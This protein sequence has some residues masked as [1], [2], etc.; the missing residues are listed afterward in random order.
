[1]REPDSFHGWVWTLS[2]AASRQ[3]RAA[4][5]PVTIWLVGTILV[6][7]GAQVATSVTTGVPVGVATTHLFYVRPGLA[8]VLSPLL[9]RGPMHAATNALLIGYLGRLVEGHFGTRAYAA[10]LVAATVGSVTGG[11]LAIV[12]FRSG[13][14]AAYGASGI[15]F[16]LAGYSLQYPFRTDPTPAEWLA[17]I[18][19]VSAVATV[20]VDV[21]TGPFFGP[22]WINGAHAVGL[23]LG[24]IAGRLRPPFA[25]R[26]RTP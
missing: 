13:P 8:W 7:F 5:S 12:A 10:F 21:A 17:A 2:G 1:M 11:Y 24:V 3:L 15:G 6:V 26:D 19:G 4:Q 25:R 9:H 20:V 14:V 22:L 23:A 16:A 18:V